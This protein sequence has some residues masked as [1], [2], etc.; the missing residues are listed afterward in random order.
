GDVGDFTLD[1]VYDDH[2]F[3]SGVAGSGMEVV[4]EGL[5]PNVEYEVLLRSFDPDAG[6][7]RSATWTEVSGQ[8]PVVI[9][10]PYNFDGNIHPTSND[11]YT[12]RAT[13]VSSAQGTLILR[14]V[15]NQSNRSVVLNA[16][17]ISRTSVDQLVQHDLVDEMYQQNASVYMRMPFSVPDA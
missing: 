17:E 10:S 15:Q 4:I 5:V 12:M 13:L 9:A 3:A 7:T 6:G 2:I 16:L 14:G 1:Q 8:N 11:A